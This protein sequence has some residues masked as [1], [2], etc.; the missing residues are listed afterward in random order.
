EASRFASR[1][2]A[3]MLPGLLLRLR[4]AAMPA[5][6]RIG[7]HA[8]EIWRSGLGNLTSR[9]FP[10]TPTTSHPGGRRGHGQGGAIMK[11]RARFH[12]AALAVSILALTILSAQAAP[13][14]APAE[15]PAA[16]KAQG[17]R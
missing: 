13:P 11:H 15:G 7:E 2:V 16:S 8:P 10:K 9:P 12:G 14:P 1:P 4:N 5:N 3:G 17:P 6:Q